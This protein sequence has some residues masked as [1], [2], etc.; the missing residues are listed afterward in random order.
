MSLTRNKKKKICS[1]LAVVALAYIVFAFKFCLPSLFNFGRESIVIQINKFYLSN[2]IE[3]I[4]I[5]LTNRN[6]CF[7]LAFVKINKNNT[8]MFSI[9]P[10]LPSKKSKKK[11]NRNR[12]FVSFIR[13]SL[14]SVDDT[15]R[16]KIESNFY[17]L[18]TTLI[19]STD[20]GK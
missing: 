12:I 1:P 16:M 7:V 15:H 18:C 5:Q 20:E 6:V 2:E 9:L 8:M 19:N 10:T 17:C 13:N 3:N 14:F 11:R 4:S